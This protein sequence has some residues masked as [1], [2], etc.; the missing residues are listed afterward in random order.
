MFQTSQCY[1]FQYKL[2]SYKG[3][4]LGLYLVYTDGTI[5]EYQVLKNSSLQKVHKDRVAYDPCGY[6]A[7]VDV[8]GNLQIV[9]GNGSMMLNINPVTKK[10]K[11]VK[12]NP[13]NRFGFKALR[14][15]VGPYLWILGGGHQGCGN[16]I[17]LHSIL[18][19]HI[20]MKYFIAGGSNMA[21]YHN[22][23]DVENS[24]LFE[25]IKKKWIPGPTL[26]QN[27]AFLHSSAIA[28]N[29][30]A[31]ILLR[32][33]PAKP[34]PNIHHAYNDVIV[35]EHNH[36]NTHKLNFIYNFEDKTW[37]RIVDM[38]EPLSIGA[39]YNLPL[40][41]TFGK[42]GTKLLQVFGFEHNNGKFL[43]TENVANLWTLNLETMTWSAQS[44]YYKEFV[45]FGKMKKV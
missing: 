29:R 21:Y 15:A 33:S 34:H 1:T 27:I 37:K 11:K 16:L 7:F 35:F 44:L 42:N 3:T 8:L 36:K 22:I 9:G 40:I 2:F 39:R 18:F 4:Y 10:R 14:V 20:L 38:P 31:V 6:A 41:I 43:L 24:Q 19:S 26:P 13:L 25:H 23:N 5:V 12:S 30:T 17:I 32:A 28:I 45:T